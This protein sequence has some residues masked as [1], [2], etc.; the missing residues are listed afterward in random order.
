MAALLLLVLCTMQP[1]AAW[2]PA[3][4]A[5]LRLWRPPRCRASAISLGSTEAEL[6]ELLSPD[7]VRSGQDEQRIDELCG[8]LC[9]QGQDRVDMELIEGDWVL[10]YTSS[11]KFD[12]RNPLGRRVDGSAPGLEGAIAAVTGG[13]D[14]SQPSSSPIQ[15]AIT[16]AFEVRQHVQLQAPEPRVTQSVSLPAGSISLSAVAR[17][18]AEL[19]GRIIF[20]FD[21]GNIDL[22][23]VRLPYP[24]PFRL[25]G[26]EA[27][28][29]L[30]TLYL[31]RTTRISAGNK[32]TTFVFQKC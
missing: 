27:V 11:S 16:S 9:Q 3:V 21:R 28:G 10:V 19:P 30:D 31:S 32:G 18:S 29:W 12:P 2:Q 4:T 23:G 20:Q 7:R 15:R 26:D 8:Q 1:L 6:Q 24:A 25:L 5:H 22:G 17:T 13:T 14:L